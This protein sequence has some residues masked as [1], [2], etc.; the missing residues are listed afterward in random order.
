MRVSSGNE[1][2]G[3]GGEGGGDSMGYESFFWE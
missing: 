3:G 1:L 2:V